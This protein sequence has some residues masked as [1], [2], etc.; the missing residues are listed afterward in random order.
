V[1]APCLYKV[2][3]TTGRIRLRIASE[4]ADEIPDIASIR[5]HSGLDH[6]PIDSH[7]LEE[8]LD[9]SNEPRAGLYA[10]NDSPLPEMLEEAAQT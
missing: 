6:T 5:A 8:F 10:H 9:Q 2:P 3:K 7:P 4:N 1:P